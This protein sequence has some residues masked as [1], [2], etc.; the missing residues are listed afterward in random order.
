MSLHILPTSLKS[1]VPVCYVSLSFPLL[2]LH[3]HNYIDAYSSYKTLD[4]TFLYIY[5]LTLTWIQMQ[6][7]KL[8]SLHFSIDT[9]SLSRQSVL[10]LYHVLHIFSQVIHFRTSRRMNPRVLRI[11]STYQIWKHTYTTMNNLWSGC[12]ALSS[13]Q[14]QIYM[15]DLTQCSNRLGSFT[16]RFNSKLDI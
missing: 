13:N 9:D 14:D 15:F 11:C 1:S 10:T 7:P 6:A 16:E 12:C 8:W 2:F 5:I 4:R 3:I